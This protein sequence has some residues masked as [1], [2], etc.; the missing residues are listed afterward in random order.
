MISYEVFYADRGRSS[1]RAG[2]QV[3]IVPTNTSS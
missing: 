3:L 2:A 1:V